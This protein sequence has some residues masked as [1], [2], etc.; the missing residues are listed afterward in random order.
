[1]ILPSPAS[2]EPS[3]TLCPADRRRWLVASGALLSSLLPPLLPGAQAA[4]GPTPVS[5]RAPAALA[6]LH[7]DRDGTLRAVSRTGEIWQASGTDWQRLGSGLDPEV[8]LAS[9]RGRVAGRSARGG[10]W[11]LE[12]GRVQIVDRVQLAPHAGLLVLDA[13]IVAVRASRDGSH[14]VVRLEPGKATWAESARSAMAV[15]PDAR[16]LQFDPAGRGTGPAAHD[17]GHVLVFGGPDDSRYRH[18]VLGDAVEATAV[19]LLDRHTLEPLRRLDLAPPHVFEDIAPRPIAWRGGHALL[20]MRSGPLGAQLCVVA[21][22][23]DAGAF[24][25]AALGEP[26]GMPNRWLS[27]STDGQRLLAVVTPHLQGVLHRYG[28]QGE[29]L[30]SEVIARGVSNHTLGQ[31]EL[32]VSAWVGS[33]WVVTSLDRR[34][35]HAID[36]DA[37]PHGAAPDII[38][39]PAPLLRLSA[40]QRGPQPGVVA[41]LQDGSAWWVPVTT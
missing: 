36:V 30:G 19:L 22:G 39:L 11:V 18:G 7:V 41:L 8:P 16:P 21:A 1:M 37:A 35:L 4:A 6:Q 10:L 17:A 15:L 40:W 29:R 26:F 14:R 34:Q 25:L 33:R 27:P 20:T 12:A 9:G 24:E 5:L 31:R 2:P 23:A 32:D 38:P 3:A 13:A 28:A